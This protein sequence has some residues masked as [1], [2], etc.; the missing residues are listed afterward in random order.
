MKSVARGIVDSLAA[1]QTDGAA[2][3]PYDRITNGDFATA[4]VWS[5]Q[6]AS[7][8]IGSG[9]ATSATDGGGL[10][11]AIAL[12]LSGTSVTITADV[13]NTNGATLT[14][15]FL[16]DGAIVQVASASIPADGPFSVT[17]IAGAEFNSV[18]FTATN[19]L[20]MTLDNVT[21]TA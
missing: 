19:F 7:W 5:I 21:L 8:T 1:A 11:Q 4:D 14:I 9:V 13:T 12:V 2:T 17:A 6:G 20:G 15:R 10:N 3:A 18:R 16:M